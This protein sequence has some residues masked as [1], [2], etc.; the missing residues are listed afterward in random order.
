MKV[1]I[2]LPTYHLF[3]HSNPSSSNQNQQ[4][5]GLS[6]VDEEELHTASNLHLFEHSNHYLKITSAKNPEIFYLLQLLNFRP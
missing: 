4:Y 5:L 6:C 3:E 1:C 2:L